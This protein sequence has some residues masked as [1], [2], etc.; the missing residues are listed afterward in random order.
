MRSCPASF[1]SLLR[2]NAT[3]Q[4]WS[5]CCERPLRPSYVNGKLPRM[6]RD[7]HWL[8]YRGPVWR[9][10]GRWTACDLDVLRR[11][12][13][14]HCACQSWID[15]LS[16][17]MLQFDSTFPDMPDCEPIH[18]IFTSRMCALSQSPPEHWQ[19]VIKNIHPLHT[20]AYVP[21]LALD[22]LMLFQLEGNFRLPWPEPGSR[23]LEKTICFNRRL[24]LDP[25]GFFLIW[26]RKHVFYSEPLWA[27]SSVTNENIPAITNNTYKGC[28]V[29]SELMLL[30]KAGYNVLGNHR[31][32]IS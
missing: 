9:R 26:A 27:T 7:G 32:M 16:S 29:R 22:L 25:L 10:W 30:C 18:P 31:L 20:K 19:P 2:C 5:R 15:F 6:S 11:W 24:R 13:S 4:R 28:V 21:W 8:S 23:S 1:H 17:F 12:T 3:S 14:G